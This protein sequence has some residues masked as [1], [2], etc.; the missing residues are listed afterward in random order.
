MSEGP[1]S[2]LS[3]VGSNLGESAQLPPL[4]GDALTGDTVREGEPEDGQSEATTEAK[5]KPAELCEMREGVSG[6]TPVGSMVGEPAIS[7]QI[8]PASEKS[9][10]VVREGE[11]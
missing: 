3:G 1:V 2:E 6:G 5:P 9:P 11:R 8:E 7:E 10:S 4:V